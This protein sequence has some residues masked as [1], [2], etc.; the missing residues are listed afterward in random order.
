MILKAC[1]VA[2]VADGISLS[3]IND[4]RQRTLILCLA[5][6]CKKKQR[7]SVAVTFAIATDF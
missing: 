2:L 7:H 4:K 1:L 3:V 5:L 6:F